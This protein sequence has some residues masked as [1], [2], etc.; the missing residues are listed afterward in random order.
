MGRIWWTKTGGHYRARRRAACQ[1]DSPPHC[2]VRSYPDSTSSAPC[3]SMNVE[4]FSRTHTR[5]GDRTRAAKRALEGRAMENPPARRWLAGCP[6]PPRQRAA[7]GARAHGPPPINIGR[8]GKNKTDRE[9]G[10]RETN[11]TKHPTAGESDTYLGTYQVFNIC[12]CCSPS[13]SSG[14]GG[15]GGSGKSMHAYIRTNVTFAFLCFACFCLCCCCC[16]AKRGGRKG[17]R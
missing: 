5:R 15:G 14:G 4:S 3:T 2:L 7:A 13:S 17:S 10:G 11:G 16:S 6:S 8:R 9:E 1:P 12:V